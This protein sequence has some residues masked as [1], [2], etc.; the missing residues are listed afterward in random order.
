MG[1][2]LRTPVRYTT[3][4][5][6]TPLQPL[7]PRA[8]KEK[9][10]WTLDCRVSVLIDWS[11]LFFFTINAVSLFVFISMIAFVLFFRFCTAVGCGRVSRTLVR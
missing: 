4:E 8:R 11:R 6:G 10:G 7:L 1:G 2:V 5:A 3:R 9:L